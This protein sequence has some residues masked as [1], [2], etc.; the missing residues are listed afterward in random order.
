MGSRCCPRH[1]LVVGLASWVSAHSAVGWPSSSWFSQ[2]R[3]WPA[4][5]LAGGI[6]LMWLGLGFLPCC[7]FDAEWCGLVGSLEALVRGGK[8][9][10]AKTRHDESHVSFS[11]RTAWPSHFLGP[12]CRSS[13]HIRPLSKNELGPHPSGEGRG[14]SGGVPWLG[15]SW[16]GEGE[17]GGGGMS[18]E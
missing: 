7:G 8:E 5:S 17:G 11:R 3:G 9:G 6:V 10:R 1:L 15:T 13:P 14:T 12:L 16:C 2:P 18:E 4:T